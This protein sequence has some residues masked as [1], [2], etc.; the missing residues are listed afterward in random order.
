MSFSIKSITPPKAP[1]KKTDPVVE[2]V[3]KDM[4]DSENN[5]E[6]MQRVLDKTN[7]AIQPK[8]SQP[9]GSSA[10]GIAIRTSTSLQN[11]QDMM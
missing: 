4:V 10:N 3:M 2:A 7:E 6:Y 9:S 8:P 5:M 1:I 11:Q